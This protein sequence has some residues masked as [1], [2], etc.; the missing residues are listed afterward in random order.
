MTTARAPASAPRSPASP[1]GPIPSSLAAHGNGQ[2]KL[3]HFLSCIH[4]REML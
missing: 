4:E 3:D 2:T 1:S